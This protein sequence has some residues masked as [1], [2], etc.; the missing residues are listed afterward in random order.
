MP[1]RKRPERPEHPERHEHSE[2]EHHSERERHKSGDDPQKHA[3]ILERRWIGSEP[4]TLERYVHALA[5]WRALSGAP[6][7]APKD[8][9]T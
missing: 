5:Q 3:A 7:P 1:Q 2:H 9:E 4:P 8:P 6:A